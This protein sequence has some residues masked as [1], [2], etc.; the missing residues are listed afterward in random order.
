MG[1][2]FI[3]ATNDD[4]ALFYNPAGLESVKNYTFELVSFGGT[5]NQST[6]D[7]AAA[8]GSDSTALL[9]AMTGGKIYNELNGS[10]LS[11]VAPGWGWSFFGGLV[12]EP[13]IHNP[14][15]PYFNVSG[16][17]QGGAVAGFSMNFADQLLD[18]GVTF[19]SISR[20]GIS[21]EVHLVDFLDEDFADTIQDEFETGSMQNAIDVGAI[22]HFENFYNYQLK[23]G[24]VMRNIGGMDF[25]STG[26]FPTTM[27][28]G[29][30][31]ESEFFGVDLLL[32]ADLID[33]TFK[34]T[35]TKS[36]KRNTNFGAEFGMFMRS[37]GQHALSYRVGMKG[38]YPSSG[39]TL[40]PH[41]L[42]LGVIPKIEYAEWSEEIGTFGGANED[43]RKSLQI[44]FNF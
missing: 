7:I 33:A 37:N 40:N 20:A 18:V 24:A 11:F 19:K 34:N 31:S 23:L 10:G 42:L 39:W 16:Y 36:L 29:V 25:G 28:F 30:A 41:F 5:I 4:S 13:E 21:K 1:N 17:V 15:V 43:K 38:G 27:D 22:Y 44:T 3:A 8:S 12:I 9:G 26:S 6:L 32:A 14:V 2:A 35:P